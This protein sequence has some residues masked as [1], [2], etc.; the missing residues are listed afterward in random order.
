MRN[1][2]I[3]VTPE[4]SRQVQEICFEN[5]I[6]WGPETYPRHTEEPCLVIEP[7]CKR[8][9]YNTE[10]NNNWGR[11]E[12]PLEEISAQDFI[13]KYS[14]SKT[15]D[16]IKQDELK[17]GDSVVI[18]C[19]YATEIC[20]VNGID[21][22]QA[23]L[24]RTNGYEGWN[25]SI[26]DSVWMSDCTS[27]KPLQ[28]ADTKSKSTETKTKFKVG[29]KV[30]RI[31]DRHADMKIGDIGTIRL[32]RDKHVVLK[33]YGDFVHSLKAL[34]LFEDN[35]KGI[36]ENRPDMVVFD[37]FI[38]LFNADKEYLEDLSAP[39]LFKR[40]LSEFKETIK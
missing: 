7:I 21:G 25:I 33:E 11:F 15:M 14:K 30:I 13:Q 9:Y 29:D 24:T 5:G 23:T 37:D 27:G 3:R 31:K 40:G 28:Y 20:T 4:E 8:V 22:N 34:E 18:S 39:D 2:K 16:G 17:I 19:Y 32:F 26:K 35:N 12:Q 36:R 6:T 38:K 10:G 1:Y